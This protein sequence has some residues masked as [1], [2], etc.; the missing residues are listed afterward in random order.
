M[1]GGDEAEERFLRVTECKTNGN[2]ANIEKFTKKE[3][4]AGVF[5]LKP[6]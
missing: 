2:K 1:F 5:L 4:D 6:G 3:R